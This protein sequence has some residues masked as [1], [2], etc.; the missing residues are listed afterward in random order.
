M[1]WSFVIEGW[2]HCQVIYRISHKRRRNNFETFDNGQKMSVH[3][4]FT[5]QLQKICHDFIMVRCSLVWYHILIT[6]TICKCLKKFYKMFFGFWYFESWKIYNSNKNSLIIKKNH[7]L[8][9]KNMRK[10]K[11]IL[12]DF[13]TEHEHDHGNR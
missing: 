1:I 6:P 7:K 9:F 12:F 8:T 13:W 5:K 10:V 4:L 2:S 11:F 3:T